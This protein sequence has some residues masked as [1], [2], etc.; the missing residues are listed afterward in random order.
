[1]PR[2]LQRSC[3]ELYSLNAGSAA[4]LL[5]AGRRPC[6]WRKGL[7]WAAWQVRLWTG[8]FGVLRGGLHGVMPSTRVTALHDSL[9]MHL[10][11]ALL[12]RTCC[13]CTAP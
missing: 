7:T 2:A 5:R 11:A 13:E 1:M 10:P 8:M 3:G 9:E 4:N 6:F 12:L